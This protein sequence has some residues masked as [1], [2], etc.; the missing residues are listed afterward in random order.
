MPHSFKVHIFKE[1]MTKEKPIVGQKIKAIRPM[2]ILERKAEGWDWDGN[3]VIEL[4]NG[5]LLYA[6]MDEEGNGPGSLFGVDGKTHF[7]F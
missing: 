5:I 3:T 4:E 6:S 1:D 7:H 2:T